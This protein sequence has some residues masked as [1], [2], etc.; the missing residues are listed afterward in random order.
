MKKVSVV[1]PTYK[2]P[3]F[4]ER[5]ID[6]VLSQDYADLEIIV[7]DDN[8]QGTIEQIETYK[9]IKRYIKLGNF[10]Y[11]AHEIN[12]NGSCARNTGIKNSSGNYICFLDDDD[13]FE[14]SKIRNQVK[15]LENQDENW[16]ACYSGHTRIYPTGAKFI[17]VPK[18]RGDLYF[19]ILASK[20]DHCAGSTLMI[21]SEVINKVGYFD[22]SF[23]RHQDIEFILRISRNY[24]IEVE[25]ESLVNIYMH[26]DSNRSKNAEQFEVR[27]KYFLE[28]FNNAIEIL[29]KNKKKYIFYTHNIDIAKQF[30]KQKNIKKGLWY[31]KASGSP[32]KG[33]YKVFLDSTAYYFRQMLIK[34]GR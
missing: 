12:L 34:L 2:R 26:S 16:G 8:G 32:F 11:I 17:H 25:K 19:E 31:V 33:L 13:Q 15:L 1:I 29:P 7:V 10:K 6:S 20:I 30:F 14:P 4:L 9:K 5:A 27:K 22:E 21:K 18:H 23:L 24:K 3:V 28:K